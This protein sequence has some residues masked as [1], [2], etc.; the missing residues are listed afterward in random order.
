MENV[1][2]RLLLQKIATGDQEAFRVL[3]DAYHNRVYSFAFRLLQSEEAAEDV[4]QDI[5]LKLW[6]NKQELEELLSVEAY[7][8][9]ITRNHTLNLLRRKDFEPELL[10]E[11]SLVKNDFNRET[12]HLIEYNDTKRI[13][14]SAIDS[15]P[16]RQQ[17]VFQLCHQDGLKYEEA[18]LKLGISSLTVK[19]H[20]QQALK[21]I[22]H[23]LRKNTDLDL[24]ILL[25]PYLL[26]L[27]C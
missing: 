10:T 19:T 20:M 1:N 25:P 2:E 17:V 16:P 27:F 6:L 15:L 5:F 8:R 22:R 4:V 14:K 21:S 18:G 13:L 24:I 7:L 3:F 11:T 23:F 26:S 12:E 9:V